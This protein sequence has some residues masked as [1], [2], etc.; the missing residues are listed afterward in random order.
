VKPLIDSLSAEV[1]GGCGW[2]GTLGKGQALRQ[3]EGAKA[4]K[5]RASRSLYTF[6]GSMD[7]LNSRFGSRP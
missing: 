6:S 1:R 2:A 5:F 7:T 3:V 4:E